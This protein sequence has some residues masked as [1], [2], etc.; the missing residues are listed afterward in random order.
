MHQRLLLFQLF[1]WLQEILLRLL[2]LLFPPLHALLLLWDGF[3][4]FSAG[5]CCCCFADIFGVA[6]FVGGTSCWG[7]G[8]TNFFP[9]SPPPSTHWRSGQIFPLLLMLL[10][11]GTTGTADVVLL[12]TRFLPRHNFDRCPTAPQDKQQGQRSSTTTKMDFP[13]QIR[14][15]G[16]STTLCW[17][18]Y[19]LEFS[20]TRHPLQDHILPWIP[21]GG[22]P[23]STWATCVR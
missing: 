21:P 4:R 20:P 14:I 6:S 10:V 2:L 7:G 17:W 9:S 23:R 1:L 16:T 11:L 8:A 12:G 3:C 22:H 5:F 15:L 18:Q 19:P 13:P